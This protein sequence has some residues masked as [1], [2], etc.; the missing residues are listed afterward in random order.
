LLHKLQERALD[1]WSTTRISPRYGDAR[2]WNT[3]DLS[4]GRY[5]PQLFL[6]VFSGRREWSSRTAVVIAS[7][8]IME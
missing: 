5:N 2:G 1:D 3:N 4:L 7:G 8:A 6:A